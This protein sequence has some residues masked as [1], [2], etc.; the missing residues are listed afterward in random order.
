MSFAHTS[1]MTI[2]VHDMVFD[3]EENRFDMILQ[4]PYI[5][6]SSFVFLVNVRSVRWVAS[7]VA[8]AHWIDR[9]VGFWVSSPRTICLKDYRPGSIVFH[10]F[11]GG[12][13]DLRGIVIVKIK[14][15]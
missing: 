9:E 11:M 4:L 6:S 3:K 14:Y 5:T 7:P 10:G 12:S 1:A 15:R 8:E 13:V 2:V